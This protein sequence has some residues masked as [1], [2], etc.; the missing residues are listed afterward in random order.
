MEIGEERNS[1]LETRNSVKPGRMDSLPALL[2]KEGGGVVV[3]DFLFCRGGERESFKFGDVLLHLIY[4]G[5]RPVG[6]PEDFVGDFFDAR[7]IFEKLLRGDAAD[8]HVKI[9]VAADQEES[10]RHPDGPPAVGEDDREIGEIDA[11]VVA[12]DGLGV[13]VAGAGENR[14]AGVNHDGEAMMLGALVDFAELGV[15]VEVGVWR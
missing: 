3:E 2:R 12:E 15:A 6:A 7:E 5:A 4:A 10:F 13:S 14:G 11:D 1:K 8:V 9:F